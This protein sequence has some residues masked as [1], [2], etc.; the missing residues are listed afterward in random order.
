[1]HAD[2][3]YCDLYKYDKGF[4]SILIIQKLWTENNGQLLYISSLYY[5]DLSTM[6]EQ[7]IIKSA[8][9]EY[10]DLR[11]CKK[12]ITLYEKPSLLE[13][14]LSINDDTNFNEYM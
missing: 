12:W 3:E 13:Q 2:I 14:A 7:Q 11:E 4:I 1:M 6:N 10:I 5:Q 8:V 9:V